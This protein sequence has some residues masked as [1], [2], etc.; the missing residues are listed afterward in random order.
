MIRFRLYLLNVGFYSIVGPIC[1]EEKWIF[2]TWI[3]I[4]NNDLVLSNLVFSWG[5][6]LARPSVCLL[7]G[8]SS[9]SIFLI[10]HF[11]FVSGYFCFHI[12][13]QI[14]LFYSHSVVD[15]FSCTFEQLCRRIFFRYLGK[16]C[17]VCIAWTS[18]GPYWIFRRKEESIIRNYYYYYY[19]TPLKIFYNSI[20]W[21]FLI[22]VRVTE[23]LL[24]SLGLFSVFWPILIILLSG[25]SPLILLFPSLPVHLSILLRIV[26]SAP[27]TTDISVTF[28]FY[29]FW[30]SSKV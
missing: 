30:F 14:V 7:R 24:K 1:R 13:L 2:K 5:L 3:N 23:S 4:C 21:W 16:F 22:G 18:S 29:S 15:L 10:Q 19:F 27:I 17:F 28:I 8:P 25:W 6:L 20:N 26:P 9:S 11:A 12:S